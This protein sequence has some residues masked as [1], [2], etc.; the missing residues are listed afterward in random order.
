MAAKTHARRRGTGS[1]R[2][3]TPWHPRCWR[4]GTERSSVSTKLTARTGHRSTGAWS[5]RRSCIGVFQFSL[6]GDQ[7]RAPDP[8]QQERLL[9][10]EGSVFSPD[11]V[12]QHGVVSS[13]L[14]SVCRPQATK[15]V[16]GGS[17][18]RTKT[19]P[20]QAALARALKKQGVIVTRPLHEIGYAWSDAQ[21]VLV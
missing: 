20:A 2:R 3:R 12:V 8:A 13:F 17:S 5:R 1:L 6:Q 16:G 21:P 10:A 11:Y 7:H 19:T 4:N 15:E 18:H 14:A 9:A